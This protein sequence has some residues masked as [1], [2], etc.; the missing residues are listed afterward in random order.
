M[1]IAVWYKKAGITTANEQ[2]EKLGFESIIWWD[3]LLTSWWSEFGNKEDM[4]LDEIEKSLNKNYSK[5]WKFL[6]KIWIWKNK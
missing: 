3:E 1:K 6:N 2:R 4:E 5:W